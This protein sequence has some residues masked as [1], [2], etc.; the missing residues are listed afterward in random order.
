MLN[1]AGR[2]VINLISSLFLSSLQKTLEG[3]R[4]RLLEQLD[5]A[6][7][8]KIDID[9][10]GKIIAQILEKHLTPNEYADYDYFINSKAKLI[11]DLREVTDRIQLTEDQLNA[12]KDTLIHSEC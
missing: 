2:H 12:L 8:L 7:R 5:E 1:Y 9:R 10:R 3:K 6:K 11:V 4:A